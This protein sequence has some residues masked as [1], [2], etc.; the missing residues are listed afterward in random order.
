MC[1]HRSRKL[2]SE[3]NSAKAWRHNLPNLS[4]TLNPNK[5]WT[6]QTLQTHHDNVERSPP[7]SLIWG[8]PLLLSNRKVFHNP[9]NR[10]TRGVPCRLIDKSKRTARTRNTA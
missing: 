3:P 8:T 9:T 6:L 7:R 1:T 5:P 2:E 10:S 4:F